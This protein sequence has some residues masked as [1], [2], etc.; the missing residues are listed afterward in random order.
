[1]ASQTYLCNSLDE[2]DA[3]VQYAGPFPM[4]L[5]ET[6]EP[7]GQCTSGAPWGLGQYYVQHHSFHNGFIATHGVARGCRIWELKFVP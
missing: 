2:S 4:F 3:A 5:A 1:M 6:P 7:F